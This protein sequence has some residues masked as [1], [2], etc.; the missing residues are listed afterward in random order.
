[1]TILKDAAKSGKRVR[2]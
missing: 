1:V 2:T